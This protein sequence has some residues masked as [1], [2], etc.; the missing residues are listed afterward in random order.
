MLLSLL[1]TGTHIHT[2]THMHTRPQAQYPIVHTENPCSLPVD[3]DLF[4]TN[5]RDGSLSANKRNWLHFR[6]WLQ[7][8]VVD[9]EWRD[10]CP[11]TREVFFPQHPIIWTATVAL[12]FLD[13]KLCAVPQKQSSWLT[14]NR[15]EGDRREE[16][17]HRIFSPLPL[18]IHCEH[19][20]S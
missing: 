18:R 6:C 11:E 10:S 3:K 20:N 19:S 8:A 5:I 13:N 9:S 16:K 12:R 17:G 15:R 7:H 4:G 14:G 2:H 1:I